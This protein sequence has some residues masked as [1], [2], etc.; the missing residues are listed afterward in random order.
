MCKCCVTIL[1]YSQQC[2]SQWRHLALRHRNTLNCMTL[3]FWF[4][5]KMHEKYKLFIFV[6]V[7]SAATNLRRLA[8]CVNLK[9]SIWTWPGEGPFVMAALLSERYESLLN[10]V[11][12][13]RYL[14]TATWNSST[15][16]NLMFTCTPLPFPFI[17]GAGAGAAAAAATVGGGG[18]NSAIPCNCSSSPSP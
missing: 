11:Q 17:T 12:M 18:G 15:V 13:L 5:F 3:S 10:Y 2:Q 7:F 6:A 4:F 14:L 9:A 8:L 1:T 16:E